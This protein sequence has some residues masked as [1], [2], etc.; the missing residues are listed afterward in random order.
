M[1]D[2]EEKTRTRSLDRSLNQLPKSPRPP[3]LLTFGRGSGRLLFG[4]ACAAVLSLACKTP[5]AFPLQ[6]TLS[7]RRFRP[8]TLPSPHPLSRLWKTP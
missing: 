6:N 4:A 7:P 8:F 3:A 5:L 2:F 1:V